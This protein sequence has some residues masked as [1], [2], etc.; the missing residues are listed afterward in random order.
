M[1]TSKPSEAEEKYILKMEEEQ[2]KKLRGECDQ[3][4]EEE[5]K[6]FQKESHWMKCPKCGSDLE[7]I[8]LQSVF[9]DKC[10]QCDGI[11]LD[12]GELELLVDGQAKMTK[13]L[14]KKLF[15]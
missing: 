7:E 13:G 8:N 12:H 14:L 15:G 10:E 6:K 5:R 9:I 11:W 2:L 4:R 3:K 1:V